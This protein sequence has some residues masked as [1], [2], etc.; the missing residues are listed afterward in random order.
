M[1]IATT[2]Y[3]ASALLAKEKG[4]FPFLKKNYSALLT[5]GYISQ[6]MPDRIK[7]LIRVYGL[8]NSHLLTVAPT[9]TTGTMLGVS[10]GLEPYFA[11]NFYR[12][13]RLGQHIKVQSK[14]IE[15]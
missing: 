11:F 9:G 6:R 12:S 5:T 7:E 15:E 14:I 13:G 2:A 10:T 4:V 3:E 1:T 8:R